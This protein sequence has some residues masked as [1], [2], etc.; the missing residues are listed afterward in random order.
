MSVGIST[1]TNT[2]ELYKVLQY[3]QESKKL[4]QLIS[5]IVDSYND[6]ILDVNSIV[7]A[8]SSR[9]PEQ[10]Q[11]LVSHATIILDRVKLVTSSLS[12]A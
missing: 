1:I 8:I 11:E 12:A 3:D 7:N 10:L 4:F 6:G 5:E 9:T 2:L